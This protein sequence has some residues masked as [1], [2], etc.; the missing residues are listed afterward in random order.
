MKRLFVVSAVAACL[1]LP[2]GGVGHPG[3]AN[4][5]VDIAQF[6]YAPQETEA[7]VGDIVNWTWRGPDTDHSV[8]ADSGQAEQFDSDPTGPPTAGTHA[9][10]D[11]FT[12]TFTKPGRFTY[13]CRTHSFMTGAVTVRSA[14]G[15]Q[16][17]GQ[18]PVIRSMRVAPKAFCAGRGCKRPR[19]V[20]DVSETA[21]LD[22][23][24]QRRRGR[25]WK[26]ARELALI[27][28]RKGS[29]RKRLSVSGLKPGRYRLIAKA[30]DFAANTSKRR[31]LLF[32][33][34]G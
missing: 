5:S 8:T 17:D 9:A 34:G 4:V 12:H 2:A 25:R 10:D 13:H 24:I 16:P 19:V 1:V 32:G 26:R 29:N 11:N 18:A 31:Q 23:Q 21:S 30:Q 6:K 22:S 28:L 27:F 33:S 14:P 20:I 15:G 3:H 7:I